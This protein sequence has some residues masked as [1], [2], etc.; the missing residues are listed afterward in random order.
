MEELREIDVVDLQSRISVCHV[1]I[2]AWSLQ[3]R[4]AAES[5]ALEAATLERLQK[6]L[7]AEEAA[8]AGAAEA[9]ESQRVLALQVTHRSEQARQGLRRAQGAGAELREQLDALRRAEEDC[10]WCS[11]KDQQRLQLELRE[12]RVEHWWIQ[13]RS[14]DAAREL[15]G[16]REERE[17][18]ELEEG[19]LLR[20][21]RNLAEELRAC[22]RQLQGLGRGE[23]TPRAAFAQERRHRH[24]LAELEGEEDRQLL[25]SKSRAFARAAEKTV[26]RARIQN[27]R[28]CTAADGGLTIAQQ[29]FGVYNLPGEED[30]SDSELSEVREEVLNHQHEWDSLFFPID[31]LCGG[32]SEEE[33]DEDEEGDGDVEPLLG[34]WLCMDT[35]G[36]E[37]FLKAN[38][39]N[40]IQRKLALSAKWPSWDFERTAGGLRFVNRTMLGDLV[41]EVCFDREY[42]NRD[43]QGNLLKCRAEWLPQKR[44]GCLRTSRKGDIGSWVEERSVSDDKLS[45]KLTHSNGAK[46]GRSFFAENV[47]GR[48]AAEVLALWQ[49]L[50]EDLDLRC[51]GTAIREIA[52]GDGDI[53]PLLQHILS[54]AESEECSDSMRG[55]GL[56][57]VLAGAAWAL[58]KTQHGGGPVLHRAEAASRRR[59]DEFA[60]KDL[61]TAAW[62]FARPSRLGGQDVASLAW[63]LAKTKPLE[64]PLLASPSEAFQAAPPAEPPSPANVAPRRSDKIVDLN[65]SHCAQAWALA[66]PLAPGRPLS[67]AI[68]NTGALG[69]PEAQQ[70]ASLARGT[71]KLLFSDQRLIAAIVRQAPFHELDPQQPSNRARALARLWADGGSLSGAAAAAFARAAPAAGPQEVSNRGRASGSI[72][73]RREPL[74]AAPS[75]AAVALSD[76]LDAQGSA[77]LAWAFA[78]CQ[79][80]DEPLFAMIGGHFERLEGELGETQHLAIAAWCFATAVVRGPLLLRAVARSAPRATELG[81]Q[82]LANVALGRAR[83]A[84]RDGALLQA[85][86]GA[87]VGKIS[88]RQPLNLSNIVRAHAS[89]ALED[90]PMLD[91]IASAELTGPSAQQPANRLQGS[92]VPGLLGKPWAQ[93]HSQHALPLLPEHTPQGPCNTARASAKSAACGEGLLG[94][95]GR[96][97]A[98]QL[99]RLQPQ[100]SSNLARALAVP[101][102]LREPF[103]RTSSAGFLPKLG[104][105]DAQA[106]TNTMRG[107]G[108]ASEVPREVMDGM[109]ARAQQQL[110]QW[111]PQ[112]PSS[113][114]WALAAATPRSRS[115]LQ[116]VAEQLA[117]RVAER[118]PQ[119]PSN[120][121]RSFARSGAVRY[122]MMDA[123]AEEA[124]RQAHLFTAQNSANAARAFGALLPSGSSLKRLAAEAAARCSEFTAQNLGNAAWAPA[125][126]AHEGAALFGATAAASAAVEVSSSDLQALSL[127]ADLPLACP[128]LRDRL[129]ATVD[130]IWH[131]F[132][133]ELWDI[134]P[135]EAFLEYIWS[136]NTD[137]LGCTGDRQLLHEMGV[138]ALAPNSGFEGRALE[139][140]SAH[141]SENAWE[142]PAEL[143]FGG[144]VRN[145]RVFSYAEYRL[146]APQVLEGALLQENGAR[147][148]SNQRS[149]LHAVQLPINYRVDRSACSE[150]LLLSELCGMIEASRAARAS[151]TLRL[152]STGP[153][154]LSCMLAIWQFCLLFPAVRV[155]VAFGRTALAQESHG[156]GHV[157]RAGVPEDDPDW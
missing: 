26:Y 110:G 68:L 10:A 134:G 142:D 50:R 97:A 7:R 156:E 54:A 146:E 135:D 141:R 67:V 36:L 31:A 73:L 4:R 116:G 43:G 140:I 91:A 90:R 34:S 114:S 82:S 69:E 119:D 46:W 2:Q 37:E 5:L 123:T 107:F 44:G 19:S 83:M 129:A 139:M 127:L 148:L 53:E 8:T 77:M 38:N 104:E 157:V 85:A 42:E 20:R 64:L 118:G 126:P 87:V 93:C 149:P 76:E 62:D 14:E 153:S 70:L 80:R 131:H 39:V 11:I 47:A 154:C 102:S 57:R 13:K 105:F 152:Y 122:C 29:Y 109:L 33:E 133:R 95:T 136:L 24:L 117:L 101:G 12:A 94:A 3:E 84:L 40:L 115:F 103:M 137:N 63:A 138:E 88:E 143:T 150:F 147:V 121:A 112:H 125:A 111:N 66:Q 79:S 113:F 59:L 6:A 16:L 108:K 124:A 75:K 120:G 144:P 35:W 56:P 96:E 30:L 17:A 32:A 61:A 155:Q 55:G 130:A 132:P 18:S 28:R 15:C 98:T 81:A 45:F 51:A 78:T 100:N 41:E 89:L 48:P 92:A 22:E 72:L 27:V 21:E 106:P 86:A 52:K 23:Q 9:A 74:F 71:G 58:A 25:R 1:E 60:P 65:G 145:R 49:S 99:P 151:G 128:Q